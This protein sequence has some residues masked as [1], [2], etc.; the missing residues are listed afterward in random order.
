[1]NTRSKFTTAGLAAGL[2]LLA[3]RLAAQGDTPAPAAPV[4]LPQTAVLGAK[5]VNTREAGKTEAVGIVSDFVVSRSTGAI[6]HA[7]VDFGSGILSTKTTKTV[8]FGELKWDAEHE[9]FTAGLRSAELDALARFDAAKLGDRVVLASKLDDQPVTSA[10]EK[11]ARSSSIVVEITTGVVAFFVLDS[12]GVLGVGATSYLAPWAALELLA[13]D[14]K[15]TPRLTLEQSSKDLEGAPKLGDGR[16]EIADPEFRAR[17]Y[18]FYGVARPTFEPAL[19]G[20][21]S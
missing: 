10:G 2:L 5:L 13:P 21:R 8:P 9:T 6:E 1:M 4:L 16:S 11:I 7:V 18:E 14:R 3:P 20:A 15:G 17:V 12:G 19:G